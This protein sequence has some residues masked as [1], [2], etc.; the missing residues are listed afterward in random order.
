MT[1]QF[2]ALV[3][4]EAPCG[5]SVLP[6]D[7]YWQYSGLQH[8]IDLL[9]CITTVYSWTTDVRCVGTYD[10][11]VAT[12]TFCTDSGSPRSKRRECILLL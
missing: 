10:C 9:L 6:A 7:K 1:F 11:L 8:H 4:G 3:F 2:M 12:R 5:C